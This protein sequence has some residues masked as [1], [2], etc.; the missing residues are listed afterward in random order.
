MLLAY[1]L[2]RITTDVFPPWKGEGS[3]PKGL[4]FHSSIQDYISHLRGMG[5]QSPHMKRGDYHANYV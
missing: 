4:L 1:S 5:N 3:L 2:K